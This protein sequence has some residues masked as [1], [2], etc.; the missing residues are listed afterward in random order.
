MKADTK[1]SVLMCCQIVGKRPTAP[2]SGRFR[3]QAGAAAALL[4]EPQTPT[5]VVYFLQIRPVCVFFEQN[6]KKHKFRFFSVSFTTTFFSRFSRPIFVRKIRL[7]SLNNIY[8]F[9]RT[10]D[11]PVIKTIKKDLK[12]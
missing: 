1:L 11:S 8:R 5:G 6:T 2:S 7:K 4:T 9:L 12:K 10:A 3:R